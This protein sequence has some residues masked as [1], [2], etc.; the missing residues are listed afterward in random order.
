[1]NSIYRVIFPR[2]LVL[3]V[4]EI[5]NLSTKQDIVGGVPCEFIIYYINQTR[6]P[7][8]KSWFVDR[9][10]ISRTKNTRHRGNMTL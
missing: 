3:L 4:H 2:C 9:V 5:R 8:T 1:M 10:L 7:P 6:T